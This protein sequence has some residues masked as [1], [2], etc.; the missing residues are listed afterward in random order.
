MKISNDKPVT[1]V[2]RTPAVEAAAGQAQRAEAKPDRVS[3]EQTRTAAEMAQNA[4]KA[5]NEDREARLKR[6]EAA[7]KGGSYRPNPSKVA[8]EILAQAELDAR[9]RALFM[10]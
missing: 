8:E 4:K 7:V 1:Q 6:L 2:D 9:L 3:V 5:V 10:G